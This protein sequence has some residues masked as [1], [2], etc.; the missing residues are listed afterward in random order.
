MITRTLPTRWEL[1][2]GHAPEQ[3]AALARE[4]GAPAAIGQILWNR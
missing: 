1:H 3:A 2:R 4:L